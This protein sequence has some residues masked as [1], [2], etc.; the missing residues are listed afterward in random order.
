MTQCAETRAFTLIETLLSIAIIAVLIGLL[1]PAL[2]SVRTRT[3]ELTS[4]STIGQHAKVFS[5]YAAHEGGAYPAFVPPA[6]SGSTFVI[7]GRLYTINGYFGQVYAWQ[8]GL[9]ESH[10]NGEIT[11]RLFQRP[12]REPDL[13][14]DY[15]YSASFMADPAF[16]NYQGRIGPSQW[17]GQRDHAVRYPSSKAILVDD[18]IM[19][20]LGDDQPGRG[21][22]GVIALVDGSARETSRSDIA[23]P[24][25][26]GDGEWPG[27]WSSG[28]RGVHTVDGV[29]GRDIR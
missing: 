15:R 6:A 24:F 14:T 3:R 18:R 13:V 1:S 11:G 22:R 2:A 21:D 29:F 4:L 16:W 8:F 10:Y 9:A 19:D 28:R 5:V 26:P 25:P 7:R 20:R 27:S 23:A 12:G 17:R